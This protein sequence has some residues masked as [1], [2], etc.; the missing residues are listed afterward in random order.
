MIPTVTAY[1]FAWHVTTSPAFRHLLAEPLAPFLDVEFVA[2]SDLMK[3]TDEPL[4]TTQPVIFCQRHP[5]PAWLAD[6]RARIVWIPMWD[7]ERGLSQSWWDALPKNLRIVAFSD[8]VAERAQAAGLPTLHLRYAQDPAAFPA[9]DWQAGRTLMYWNRT[10]LVSPRAIRRLCELFDVRQVLFRGTLDPYFPRSAAYRLPRRIGSV[11]VET[12]SDFVSYQDYLALLA[13]TQIYV[14]PRASEGVGMA[15]LEAMASGCAV[16]AADAPTMN[17]RINHTHTGILLPFDHEAHEI[18]Q[19]LRI[20]RRQRLVKRWR[21]R[22]FGPWFRHPITE[23]EIDLACLQ[24]L[25]LEALGRAARQSL[26]TEHDTWKS[27]LAEY[28]Q[29]ILDW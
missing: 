18:N 11:A 21:R 6:D 20:F 16:L 15:F 10:G 12:F 19:R 28:A 29:F 24:P 7:N 27:R 23:A 22:L 5:F 25:N 13:R 1:C 3:D 26:A 14:A 17:E 8:A 4:P 2:T 9:V